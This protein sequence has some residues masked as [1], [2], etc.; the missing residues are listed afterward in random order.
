MT[1][2]PRRAAPHQQGCSACLKASQWP[3]QHIAGVV[4]LSLGMSERSI[5]ANRHANDLGAMNAQGEQ[6]MN[7]GLQ[8]HQ[9][10]AWREYRQAAGNE[11]PNE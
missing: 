10:M 3:E 11:S 2:Q 7:N 8:L 5:V 6:G 9:G 1:A 4:P